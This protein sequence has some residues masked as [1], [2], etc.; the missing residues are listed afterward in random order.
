VRALFDGRGTP[1]ALPARKPIDVLPENDAAIAR[2]LLEDV[3][4]FGISY[5]LRAEYGFTRPCGGKTGTTNDYHDA[6]FVGFTPELAAGVWVGYDQPQSL[7]RPAAKVAI[8]VWARVMNR[9]LAGFP[10]TA[11]PVRRD[12]KQSRGSIRTRAAWRA[13][14]APRRCAW[15]SW[16][17]PSRRRR[18]RRTTPPTGLR[19]RRARPPTAWPA[20]P[21]TRS[22]T[23]IRSP[24]ARRSDPPAPGGAVWS[25]TRRDPVYHRAASGCRSPGTA[26][27]VS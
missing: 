27:E 12:V 9:V 4:T 26:H 20:P 7:T 19:S 14:T 8:P 10:A 25:T 22:R 6:W 3:V 15:T 2:G 18:A 1:M 13:A 24:A 16:P 21:G 23:P 17:A 5:P 11:F